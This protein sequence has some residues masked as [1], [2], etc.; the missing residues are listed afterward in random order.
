MNS[1][2][3]EA[4]KIVAVLR[5]PL[6]SKLVELDLHS[7]AIPLGQE[8]ITRL[9]GAG[10]RLEPAP[11]ELQVLTPDRGQ[12]AAKLPHVDYYTLGRT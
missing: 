3:F 10:Q 7:E 4:R 5:I 1:S 8:P 12:P 11:F 6:Q 2:K 9:L